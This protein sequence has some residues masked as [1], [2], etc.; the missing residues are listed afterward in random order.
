M[1]FKGSLEKAIIRN[2]KAKVNCTK[3]ITAKIRGKVKMVK[4]STNRSP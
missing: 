2:T 4:K 3:S 1:D